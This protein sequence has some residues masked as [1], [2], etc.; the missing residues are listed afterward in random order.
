MYRR[1]SIELS[2]L[3]LSWKVIASVLHKRL[4]LPVLMLLVVAFECVWCVEMD[5]IGTD[6]S[7]DE[8]VMYENGIEAS[9]LQHKCMPFTRS[10]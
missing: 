5:A 3:S 8:R 10:K 1:T 2:K 6:K 7:R 4:S 9:N